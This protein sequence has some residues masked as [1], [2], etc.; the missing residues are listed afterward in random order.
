[1]KAF[2]ALYLLLS[3]VLSLNFFLSA[4]LHPFPGGVFVSIKLVKQFF[5]EIFDLMHGGGSEAAVIGHGVGKDPT[6]LT[7]AM[8]YEGK[9]N[10]AGTF[11]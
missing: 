5:L 8:L 3:E 2:I 6:G 4:T 10:L 7:L 1:L 11:F 9:F